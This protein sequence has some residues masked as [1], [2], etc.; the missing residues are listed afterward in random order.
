MDIKTISGDDLP[1]GLRDALLSH[2]LRGAGERKMRPARLADLQGL[3]TGLG[4]PKFEI[5]DIV[6]LRKWAH[7]MFKWPT[8]DDK[9]I[10]TQVLD[11]PYRR[12]DVGTAESAKRCDFALAFVDA[13]GDVIEYL[14]DSRMFEKVASIYDPI[15]LPDGEVLPTC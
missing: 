14:H 1:P 4:Q 10:V 15:V 3:L 13:D 2:V 6:V 12:G 11:T 7:R 9:C 8:A 5:G